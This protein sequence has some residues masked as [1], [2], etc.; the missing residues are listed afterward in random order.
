MPGTG[1]SVGREQCDRREHKCGALGTCSLYTVTSIIGC[2][3]CLHNCVSDRVIQ[4]VKGKNCLEIL[5]VP[6]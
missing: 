5:F 2:S 4:T 1:S 6:S 3:C